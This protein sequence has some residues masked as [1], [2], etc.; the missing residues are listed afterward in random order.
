MAHMNPKTNLILYL[1]MK[2][3]RGLGEWKRDKHR[4]N[5]FEKQSLDRM[6]EL[7]KFKID[8]EKV[9]CDNHYSHFQ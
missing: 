1:N 3:G 8:S 9:K 5:L 6:F 4:N 7:R 2:F